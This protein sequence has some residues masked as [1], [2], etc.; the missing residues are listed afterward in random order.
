MMH[1]AKGWWLCCGAY[2]RHLLELRLP[3]RPSRDP[4]SILVMKTAENRKTMT[5]PFLSPDEPDTTSR[6]GT[7]WLMP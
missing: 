4:S 3:H 5:V 6:S 7:R 2:L 1:L